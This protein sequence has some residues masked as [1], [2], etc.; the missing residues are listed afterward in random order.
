MKFLKINAKVLLIL[1]LF[2]GI[3]FLS[4]GC[5]DKDKVED[6]KDTEEVDKKDETKTDDKTT[7]TTE[8]KESTESKTTTATTTE[9]TK[10]TSDTTDY[11]VWVANTTINTDKNQ[12]SYKVIWGDTLWLISTAWEVPY[13]EIARYNNIPNPDLIYVDQIIYNPLFK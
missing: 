8:N 5:G 6:K 10:T 12:K 13:Q 11:S 7:T 4:T 9:N 2:S 1:C 3:L